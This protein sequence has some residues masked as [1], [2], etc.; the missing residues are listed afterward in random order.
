MNIVTL[1]QRPSQLQLQFLAETL[2]EKDALFVT[3]G[4]ISLSY[5]EKPFKAIAYIRESELKQCGG[6]AHESWVAVSDEYW[7]TFLSSAT[8]HIAW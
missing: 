2:T 5:S 8:K 7:V 1:S 6:S 3:S 4:S